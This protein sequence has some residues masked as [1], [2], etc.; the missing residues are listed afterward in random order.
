MLALLIGIESSS[1]MDIL[2][3][4]GFFNLLYAHTFSLFPSGSPELEQP[5]TTLLE[6]I[7]SGPQ[8]QLA[9]KYRM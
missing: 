9:I 2:E 6:R 3:I 8:E 5:V 1:S 4:E 7:A